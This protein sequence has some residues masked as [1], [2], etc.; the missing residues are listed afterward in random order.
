MSE[1]P[2]KV[3]SPSILGLFFRF[4]GCKNV[5]LQP[6][7]SKNSPAMSLPVQQCP[8]PSNNFKKPPSNVVPRPAMPFPKQQFQKTVLQCRSLSC[9][10]L[11]RSTMPFPVLQ[12]PSPSNNAF[13]RRATTAFNQKIPIIQPSK[14]LY[15]YF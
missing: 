10:I 3:P 2:S 7:I 14:T 6:T 11:P 4:R 15:H 5:P 13:P 8:S 9:N 12:C 1:Y